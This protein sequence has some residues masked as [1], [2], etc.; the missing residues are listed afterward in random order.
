M[1]YCAPFGKPTFD[2]VRQGEILSQV[3]DIVVN[4]GTTDV[5]IVKRT[6][7]T[8]ITPDCDI[9]RQWE[10]LQSQ[11]KPQL[12]SLHF[13]M[14]WPS[15]DRNVFPK[16]VWGKIKKTDHSSIQA[17][18]SCIAEHDLLD[19]GI[20]SLSFNFRHLFSIPAELIYAGI[21]DGTILRRT[22][23]LS[24]YRDHLVQRF[25]AY[26]GRVPLDENHTLPED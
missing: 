16:S 4:P 6:Y 15:A 20:P 18:G 13:L 26:F 2:R 1:T 12:T 10:A 17:I 5:S 24:P 8:I 3:P 21:R 7:A 23:L 22:Q 9:E 11:K 19:E 25:C 14:G